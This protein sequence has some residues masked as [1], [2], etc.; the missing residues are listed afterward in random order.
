M[1]A[2]T[3]RDAGLQAER[4]ALAWSRTAMAV[5]VNALAILRAGWTRNAPPL[6]ALGVML[7]IAAG[8][9]VLCGSWRR[10]QL[11]R[12]AAGP[13]APPAAAIAAAAGITLFACAAGL[14][15]LLEQG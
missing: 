1:S 6:S 3:P 12:G 11:S 7:L 15:S 13:I 4:T 9:V 8:A 5:F 10:R 2:A 14:V